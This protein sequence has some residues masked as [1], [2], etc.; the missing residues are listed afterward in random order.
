[1]SWVMRSLFLVAAALTALVAGGWYVV[2][3]MPGG[4]VAGSITSR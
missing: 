2:E 1:M 4:A 3:W